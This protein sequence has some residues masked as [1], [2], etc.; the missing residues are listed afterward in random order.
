MNT[1]FL[2][3]ARWNFR[4]E[5]HGKTIAYFITKENIDQVGSFRTG[6]TINFIRKYPEHHHGASAIDFAASLVDGYKKRGKEIKSWSAPAGKTISFG[7]QVLMNSASADP[8]RVHMFA[9]ANRETGIF[10]SFIFEAPE[11]SWES[12]VKTAQIFVNHLALDDSL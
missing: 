1:S 3:P 10:Y 5:D 12:E 2:L 8:Y 7:A 11:S 6:V 4:G 9:V